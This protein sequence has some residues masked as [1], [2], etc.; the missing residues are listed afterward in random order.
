MVSNSESLLGLRLVHTT[1]PH[2]LPAEVATLL[3][4]IIGV[5]FYIYVLLF[6]FSKYS[7]VKWIV[8]V[9]T[10]SNKVDQ[11]LYPA[12]WVCYNNEE[13]NFHTFPGSNSKKGCRQRHGVERAEGVHR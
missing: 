8:F 12:V 3:T 10:K 13:S 11:K 1:H 5:I 6:I 9:I 7:T 2:T 4:L